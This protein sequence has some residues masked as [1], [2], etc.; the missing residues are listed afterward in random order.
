M[1]LSAV[2]VS[3]NNLTELQETC[4][5]VDSQSLLPN[6]HWVI[7]ASTNSRIKDWLESTPQPPYRKWICEPDRGISDGFNKGIRHAAS[8]VVHLLNSGDRYFDN[9]AIESAMSLLGQYP[10]ATWL[11]GKML[12]PRGGIKIVVGA[13]FERQKLYRGMRT[14]NHQTFFVKKSLYEKYGMFSLQKKYAMDYDFLV[15]IAD[16]P[17]VFCE[18]V[19]VEF[20]GGGVSEKKFSES[21][22]EVIQSYE[23][24][25]GWSLKCRLWAFRTG[26]L[27]TLTHQNQIVKA[28][29]KFKNRHNR[30][31]NQK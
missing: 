19:L 13:P 1:T 6:E 2:T 21:L 29:F 7:D 30:I 31:T 5:S 4:L 15:R 12:V 25:F 8:Q 14:L 9:Q 28:V 20:E 18:S 23:S 26:L 22:K 3:F 17:F 24:R 10:K 11:H 16:E 27:F